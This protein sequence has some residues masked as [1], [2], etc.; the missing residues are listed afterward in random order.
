MSKES[1]EKHKKWE[2]EREK[3]GS[4]KKP[5]NCKGNRPHNFVLTIPTYITKNIKFTEEQT[6]KYYEEKE[7][8]RKFFKDQEKRYEE[9]GLKICSYR[10]LSLFYLY[11]CSVCGKEKYKDNKITK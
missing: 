11:K 2:E 4:L 10:T 8:E 6:L 3:T 9:I 1:R 7:L 5:V